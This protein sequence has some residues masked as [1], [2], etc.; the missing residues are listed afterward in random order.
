MAPML[1]HFELEIYRSAHEAALLIFELS[2]SFPSDD[3]SPISPGIR[4]SSRAVYS[5]IAEAWQHR[6]YEAAFTSKLTR[7]EAKAAETQ[8]WLRFAAE[9][10][11]LPTERALSLIGVYDGI[12]E[13]LVEMIDDPEPWLLPRSDTAQ[14]SAAGDA[15]QN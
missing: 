11:F 14:A 6:I 7:A 15:A 9:R 1:R 3:D 12:I 4:G 2:E 8:T 10:G 5:G 13:G